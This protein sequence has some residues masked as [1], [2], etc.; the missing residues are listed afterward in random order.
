MAGIAAE[1]LRFGN[2]EGGIADERALVELFSSIQPPWNILRIQ[3]Q[4]RWSVIQAMALIK[5]HQ[6]SYDAIVKVF[7][8]GKGRILLH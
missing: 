7:E 4:A 8:E 3:G 5:E 6:A 1:A 2:T